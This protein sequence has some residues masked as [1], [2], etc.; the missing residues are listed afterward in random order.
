MEQSAR[1]CRTIWAELAGRETPFKKLWKSSSFGCL[2]NMAHLLI[3]IR[4]KLHVDD[5]GRL[6]SEPLPIT[7]TPSYPWDGNSHWDRS[8]THTWWWHHQTLPSH[9]CPW[10][11]T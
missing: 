11:D 8:S 6:M 1:R 9:S 10:R 5:G 2:L 4:T 7:M 3:L